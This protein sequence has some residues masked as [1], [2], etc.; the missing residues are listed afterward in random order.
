M[1]T[2]ILSRVAALYASAFVT[3]AMVW[4][5]AGYALP[6]AADARLVTIPTMTTQR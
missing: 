5:I 6:E 2:P 4:L 1:N 3:L